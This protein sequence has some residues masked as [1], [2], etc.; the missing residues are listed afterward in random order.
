M[1]VIYVPSGDSPGSVRGVRR[2]SSPSLSVVVASF[3]ERAQLE[4]GLDRLLPAAVSNGAEVLVVRAD[5]PARL[6]ELARAYAG[7]RFVVA[8]PGSGRSELLSLGMAES[9]GHVVALTDDYRLMQEDWTEIL[10]HRIGTLSPGPGLARDGAPVDWIKHLE[11]AGSKR[12][13]PPPD[14]R[15]D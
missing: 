3:Q 14:R 7:V 8:P 1:S 9:S 4:R 2:P 11:N 10:A 13:G 6:S 15:A 5:S 12:P